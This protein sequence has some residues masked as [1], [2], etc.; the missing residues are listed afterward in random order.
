M[1]S[2]G[3]PPKK[4]TNITV[5]WSFLYIWI[6]NV[7]AKVYTLNAWWPAIGI[8]WWNPEGRPLEAGPWRNNWNPSLTVSRLASWP[9]RN[10][11]HSPPWHSSSPHTPKQKPTK[12]EQWFGL[13]N[14]SQHELFLLG[15]WFTSGLCCRGRRM[16]NIQ[17]IPKVKKSHWREICT[18]LHM[19]FRSL[20][21]MQNNPNVQYR[22][23][24]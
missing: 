2:C 22:A 4:S 20:D 7:P 6:L 17:H 19:C 1:E 24:R 16:N 18:F 9:P 10:V 23:N 8:R 12:H 13:W 14:L 21:W 11:T 15:S 5:S 3:R